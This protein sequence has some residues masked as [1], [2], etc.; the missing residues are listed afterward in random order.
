MPVD[1][2]IILALVVVPIIWPSLLKLGLQQRAAMAA[3]R[4]HGGH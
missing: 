4:S 1:L 2:P 3:P